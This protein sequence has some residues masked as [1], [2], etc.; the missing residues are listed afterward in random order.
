VLGGIPAFAEDFL[1]DRHKESARID[2][3]AAWFLIFSDNWEGRNGAEEN[4]SG[5]TAALAVS[6]P[7]SKAGIKNIPVAYVLRGLSLGKGG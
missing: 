6:E 3:T 1:G 2:L 5:N 4:L 7:N